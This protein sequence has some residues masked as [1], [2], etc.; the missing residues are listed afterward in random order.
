MIHH[1]CL[2]GG[3]GELNM[4]CT[5]FGTLEALDKKLAQLE[6]NINNCQIEAQAAKD[7][8][9]EIKRLVKEIKK[10]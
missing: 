8:M 6:K 4:N 5:L 1:F 3:I 2:K 9:R 7:E 10:K